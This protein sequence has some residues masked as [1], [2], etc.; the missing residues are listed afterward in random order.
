MA[1]QQVVQV[2]CD[3]CTRVELQPA[4]AEKQQPDFEASLG[5]KKIQYQDVCSHCRATLERLW[6]D[7]SQWNRDLKQGFLGPSVGNNEAPPMVSAPNF[8]PPKPHSK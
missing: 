6:E 1:R 7:M 5:E 4:S 3:R 8:T 2:K